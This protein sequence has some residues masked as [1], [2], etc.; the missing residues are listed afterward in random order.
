M[1]R[2]TSEMIFPV[3]EF[4]PNKAAIGARGPLHRFAE[5]KWIPDDGEYDLAFA[6]NNVCLYVSL[7]YQRNILWSWCRGHWS[8]SD[9]RHPRTNPWHYMLREGAAEWGGSWGRD[10]HPNERAGRSGM[11]WVVGQWSCANG[12]HV[13][14]HLD[15]PHI[16]AG[17]VR[18]QATKKIVTFPARPICM[19]CH[20]DGSTP[21]EIAE[22]Y[23]ADFG[24]AAR[25]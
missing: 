8:G 7:P 13:E 3:Y 9:P 6:W 18:E 15:D 22:G 19:Y 2:L 5:G 4:R 10:E 12:H 17:L 1:P 11:T 20:G 23:A 21:A 14:F 24:A 16:A 25:P